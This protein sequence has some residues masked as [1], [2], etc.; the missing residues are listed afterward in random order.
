LKMSH[1]PNPL[2][3]LHFQFRLCNVT[4]WPNCVRAKVH[5]LSFRNFYN[6]SRF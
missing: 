5:A 4:S 2:K 6:C 1:F 3:M